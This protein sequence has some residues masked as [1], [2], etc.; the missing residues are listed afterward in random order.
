MTPGMLEQHQRE[1]AHGLRLPWHEPIHDAYQPDHLLAELD[2]QQLPFRRGVPLIEYEVED[3]EYTAEPF[4][5]ELSRRHAVGDAGV[6]DLALRSDQT[7]LHCRLGEQ[8]SP[9]DLA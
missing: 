9:S 8:E 7:L 2:A 5:K 6:S 1:Q 3:G 4:R